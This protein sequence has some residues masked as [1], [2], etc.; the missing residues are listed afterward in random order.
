[1]PGLPSS[2]SS[3]TRLPA[4][5]RRVCLSIPSWFSAEAVAHQGFDYVCIDLQH[6]MA[7]YAAAAEMLLAIHSTEAVP[8]VRVPANDFAA[9]N[10]MLDAG[11]LGIIVPMIRSAE[12]A[13]AAVEACRYP[14]HGSRSYGPA[15]AAF[16]AGPAYFDAANEAYGEKAE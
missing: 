4:R 15:R 13:R 5:W 2:E 7:D 8:I 16:A 1:M 12:D 10:R 11:A 3:A 14:P 6:G 9:I